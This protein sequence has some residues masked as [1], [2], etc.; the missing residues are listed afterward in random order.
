MRQMG[1][2]TPLCSYTAVSLNG[3]YVGLYVAMEG[4]EVSFAVRNFGYD[5][6]LLYKPEQFDVAGILNGEYTD[7][8]TIDSSQLLSENGMVQING[9]GCF[10]H[11]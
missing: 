5:Y 9:F 7:T 10:L 3:E 6:G 8:V 2:P 1:V 11:L 4:V